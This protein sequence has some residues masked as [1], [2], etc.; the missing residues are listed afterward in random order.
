MNR[1]INIVIELITQ[2]ADVNKQN[3]EGYTPLIQG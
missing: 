2:G 3:K 1:H